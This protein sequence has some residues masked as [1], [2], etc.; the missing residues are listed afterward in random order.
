MMNLVGAIAGLALG[1]GLAGLLEFL[2][3]TLR[4]DDDVLTAVSLPVLAMIP[5]M[6]TSAEKRQQLRGR[7]LVVASAAVAIALGTA[8]LFWKVA[9]H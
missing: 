4:T 9:A 1:L 8:A 5:L 7:W 6:V 3:T 2:D